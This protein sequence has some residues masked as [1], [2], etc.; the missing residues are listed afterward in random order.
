[1]AVNAVINIKGRHHVIIQS[2]MD[3][4]EPAVLQTCART[5]LL[6]IYFSST[7]RTAVVLSERLVV[8]SPAGSTKGSLCELTQPCITQLIQLLVFQKMC[9]GQIHVNIMCNIM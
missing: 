7:K 1:M 3:L 2:Q 6:T 5:C 4:K 9:Y 8:M